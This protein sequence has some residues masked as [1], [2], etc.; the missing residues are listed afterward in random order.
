MKTRL[1]ASVLAALF[2]A[3]GAAPARAQS[4]FGVN[5]LGEHRFTGGARFR[6]LGLSSYAV[7]D[8]SYAVAA[9]DASLADISSVTFSIFESFTSSG[10]RSGSA[11][12]D[13]NRFQL[14]TVMLGVPLGKRFAAAVGYRER[15]EG[16]GEF[17]YP[18]P[19]EGGISGVERYR[20]RASLFTV[21]F[22]AAWK[23]A[24][25]A[26]AAASLNLERGS[27]TDVATV[28]FNNDLY[29]DVD[30][31]RERGY[32]GL[33][34]AV[35]VLVEP[36]RRLSLGAGFNSAV[37]YD[38][39]ESFTYSNDA[40]DSS[41]SWDFRLP[42]S[43][44]AGAAVG[45]TER[46]WLSSYFWRREAPEPAGFR[47]LEG[48]IGDER[49]VSFG[50][51]RRRSKEGGFFAR[52]PIRA[53]FYEDRWHLEYPAGRPVRSRFF[54]LGSGFGLPGGPGAIDFALEFGQ[55]G[56]IGD[57]GAD[58]RVFRFSVSVSASEAWSRRRS[59]R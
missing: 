51:E 8:T 25:W 41:A 44:G 42:P 15:F 23:A 11:S 24:P 34:W 7:R 55:I 57:N 35:S 28:L 3:S 18:L 29:G 21:P 43:W 49:L 22:V 53:G 4:V 45:V 19:V 2:L 31:R 32:A 14:P 36:H 58:E 50:V 6:A 13:V 56:S 5:F 37:E 16:R 38:V 30:S 48:S 47:Q 20:H 59:E 27:I 12:A 10:V 40:L 33:S 52:A 26:S 46:W 54:T 1:L 39:T 17:S 9:N